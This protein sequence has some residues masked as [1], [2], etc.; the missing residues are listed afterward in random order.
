[1]GLI[2]LQLEKLSAL[3]TNGIMIGKYRPDDVD[4][5]LD[6]FV[7]YA[8]KERYIDQL[9][10][11]M[12]KTRSGQIPISNFVEKNLKKMSATLED[13]THVMQCN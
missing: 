12:I 2:Y 1:M 7:R 4:D 9:D 11:I 13:M 8:E 6:I 10:N 3:V 5:E